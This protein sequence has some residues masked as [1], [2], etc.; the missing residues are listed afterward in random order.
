[1]LKHHPHHPVANSCC[2]GAD[3]CSWFLVVA[4]VAKFSN[5]TYL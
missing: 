5:T 2:C 4:W 3:V 1:L